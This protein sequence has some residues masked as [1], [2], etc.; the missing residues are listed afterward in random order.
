MEPL[1]PKTGEEEKKKAGEE[2]KKNAFLMDEVFCY[3]W[4]EHS[5]GELLST[6]KQAVCFRQACLPG[7]GPPPH[8]PPATAARPHLYDSVSDT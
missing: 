5:C 8:P 3:V 1:E 7:T 6:R 4:R 2:E